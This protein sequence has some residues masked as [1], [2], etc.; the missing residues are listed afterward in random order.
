[1]RANCCRLPCS[2]PG[3]L[4][5]NTRPD[6]RGSSRHTCLDCLPQAKWVNC[7][8]ISIVVGPKPVAPRNS[9]DEALSWGVAAQDVCWRTKNARSLQRQPAAMAT[10]Q[11]VQQAHRRRGRGALRVSIC[12]YSMP[13]AVSKVSLSSARQLRHPCRANWR[14]LRQQ[15]RLDDGRAAESPRAAGGGG[16]R[17]KVASSEF[18]IAGVPQLLIRFFWLR[19]GR[20]LPNQRRG[21]PDSNCCKQGGRRSALVPEAA[22][23][24]LLLFAELTRCAALCA[25]V[26][27]KNNVHPLVGALVG[28]RSAS[29]TAAE[30]GRSSSLFLVPLSVARGSAAPVARGSVTYARSR[31]YVSPRS[32]IALIVSRELGVVLA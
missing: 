1:L 23:S 24:S 13:E 14:R 32:S 2:T 17:C 6:R 19:S 27:A 4:P 5:S 22:R 9:A 25:C 12:E 20:Y 16:G 28:T 26:R 21:G 29:V 30:I 18:R 8:S 10:C 15:R 31:M 7:G 11:P 3:W